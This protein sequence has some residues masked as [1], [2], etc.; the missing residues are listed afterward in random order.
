MRERSALASDC[1]SFVKGLI[2]SRWRLF[3]GSRQTAT[4]GR[5]VGSGSHSLR[6]FSPTS[7]VSSHSP[8]T[9]TLALAIVLPNQQWGL[10]LRMPRHHRELQ[11]FEPTGIEFLGISVSD[12]HFLP[13]TISCAAFVQVQHPVFPVKEAVWEDQI[14]SG[15]TSENSC[16][17]VPT[18]KE[19]F[20][21]FGCFQHKRQR[22]IFRR[23][24]TSWK[25]RGGE[26]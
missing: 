7:P 20:S 6:R 26:Q 5:G 23:A 8:K 16:A 17:N 19:I 4:D 10:C 21:S 25:G 11:V 14:P 15:S 9:R 18:V 24:S 12:I 2:E 1:G 3:T 13:P 22:C